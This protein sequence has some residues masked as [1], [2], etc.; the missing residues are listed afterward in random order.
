MSR[1]LLEGAAMGKP[2]IGTDVAGSRDLIEDGVT[3]LLCRPRDAGSLA[4][5]MERMGRMSPD[6]LR[7][8]GRV[9]RA[10]I[11]REF[12]ELVVVQAYLDVL[13]EAT[14]H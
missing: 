8:M 9:G 14:A 11:E 6:E 7:A 5:A 12:S 1:A 2:L 4:D 3:G 10:K 13:E